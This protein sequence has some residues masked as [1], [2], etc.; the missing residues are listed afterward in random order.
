MASGEQKGVGTRADEGSEMGRLFGGSGDFDPLI[1][2][3][4]QQKIELK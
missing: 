1:S 4:K 2:Q 3:K